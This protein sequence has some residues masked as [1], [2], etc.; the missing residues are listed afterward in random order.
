MKLRCA[1]ISV[2]PP[3][4]DV[5]ARVSIDFLLKIKPASNVTHEMK[6]IDS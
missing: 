2:N 3:S 6:S 1:T 4:T 5:A